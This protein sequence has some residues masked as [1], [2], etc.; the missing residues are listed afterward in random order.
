[1]SL[2]W[3]DVN[4]TTIQTSRD[5][6]IPSVGETF[7]LPLN[8][9]IDENKFENFVLNCH[10]SV[11]ELVR[12]IKYN[13]KYVSYTE[14]ISNFVQNINKVLALYISL[15][16]HTTNRPIYIMIGKYFQKKSNYWLLLYLILIILV[17]KLWLL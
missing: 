13:T 4:G 16:L 12:K 7:K 8:H 15:N 10:E 14:F 11:K 6:Y 2:F 3:N 17:L 1:M 5:I 9:E